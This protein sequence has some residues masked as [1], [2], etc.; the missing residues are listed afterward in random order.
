VR[1]EAVSPDL[2]G[3]WI[4]STSNLGIAAGAALGGAILEAAGIRPVAWAAAI[5]IAAALLMV[6]L[7]R[8]AVPSTP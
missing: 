8:R 3:D 5:A 2:A 1:T 4:V 7:G 6:V